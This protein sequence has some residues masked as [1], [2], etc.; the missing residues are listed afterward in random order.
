MPLI[1]RI[2]KDHVG[3]HFVFAFQVSRALPQV[4]VL[5]PLLF[6]IYIDD[7]DDGVASKIIKFADDTNIFRRV[8]TRHQCHTL[9]E[10]LNRLVPWSAKWQ[11]LFNQGKCKCLHIGRAN[12]KETYE[13]HNAFL[14][15]TSKENYIGVTISADWKVSE[16]CGIAS[17]K[18]HQIPGM[19]K[20]NITYRKKPY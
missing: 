5:G 19:I 15:K 6:L 4:S 20:I 13:M 9:H 17:R 11:M 8:Q 7:L 2:C 18:G 1:G 14:L 3:R 10:G 16:Q 12:G